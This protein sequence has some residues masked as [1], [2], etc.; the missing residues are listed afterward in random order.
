MDLAR[1]SR[2]Q[3]SI[4]R[5]P[6]KGAK[7]TK[8]SQ[9]SVTPILCL[10]V[11]FCGQKFLSEK[12]FAPHKEIGRFHY[13]WTRMSKRE[14]RRKSWRN[15]DR[16][17]TENRFPSVFCSETTIVFHPANTNRVSVSVCFYPCPSVVQFLWLRPT[18][19]LGTSYDILRSSAD[20]V[21]SCA[22]GAR[23]CYPASYLSWFL[24]TFHIG[25]WLC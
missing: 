7:G 6:Q 18:A 9:R 16:P 19:A 24:P 10:F 8:K 1:R 22:D 25:V 21:A 12:I 4:R 3:N 11:T 23:P 2:N 14:I 20:G 13:G 17:L 5:E 15:H